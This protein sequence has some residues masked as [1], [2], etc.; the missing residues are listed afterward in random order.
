MPGSC[1]YYFIVKTVPED[2]IKDPKMRNHP[3]QPG[4]DLNSILSVHIRHTKGGRG[5][6]SV[7][8]EAES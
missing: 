4:S 7:A 3:E 5:G 6:S 1:E 8:T 2:A